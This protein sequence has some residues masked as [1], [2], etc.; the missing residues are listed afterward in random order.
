MNRS[1]GAVTCNQKSDSLKKNCIQ[2]IILYIAT[3]K[4]IY[5]YIYRPAYQTYKTF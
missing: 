1:Y 3:Q 4:I 5:I 2:K